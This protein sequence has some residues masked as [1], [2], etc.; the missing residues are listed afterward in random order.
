M[1]KQYSFS[2]IV[3]VYRAEKYLML[4]VNSLLRQSYKNF[5]VLFIDDGSPDNCPLICDNLSK[6]YS[7]MKVIHQNNAGVS[8][9]RNAGILQANNDII[10]FLDA[11]DEWSNDHLEKLNT[12]F[13]RY[14]EIGSASTGRYEEYSDG[15]CET[16][17]RNQPSEFGIIDDILILSEF[18]HLRTSSYC[19]KK[20][21]LLKAGLFRVG[22][23]RGEDVDVIVRVACL[24]K[25]GY[26]ALPLTTYRVGTLYNSDNAPIDSYFPFYEFYSLNY[27]YK[28]SLLVFTGFLM[29]G[30][31]IANIKA[32]QWKTAYFCFCKTKVLQYVILRGLRYIKKRIWR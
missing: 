26:I 19:V 28:K 9:A 6:E 5:E 27:P 16:I 10:C 17:V 12:L 25:H 23:K 11:D 30:R 3:P 22:I 8:A 29:Q 7:F 2:I 18:G 14:P 4:T 15:H 20:D 1:M 32:H 24:A 31:I 13:V 21:I